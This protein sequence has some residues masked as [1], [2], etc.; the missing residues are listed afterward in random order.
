MNTAERR[1]QML[2]LITAVLPALVEVLVPPE[3]AK[4]VREHMAVSYP[5]GEKSLLLTPPE[6]DG[7]EL[8]EFNTTSLIGHWTRVVYPVDEVSDTMPPDAEYTEPQASDVP[9]GPE[10]P[11]VCVLCGAFEGQPHDPGC[12]QAMRDHAALSGPLYRKR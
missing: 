3:R 11:M 5:T 4:P 8:V 9:F 7:W 2:G 10:A 12:T 1:Q 6:G